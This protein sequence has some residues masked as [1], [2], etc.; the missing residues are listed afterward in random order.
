MTREETVRLLS[1]LRAAYPNFYKGMGK[2]ELEGTVSLW[3]ELFLEDD[4]TLVMT[5]AKAL[6]VSDAKGFPP[7]IG[8]IKDK[9]RLLSQPQEMGAEEA[10]RL[11]QKALSNGLYG[12]REEYEKLPER[13]QGLIG[14]PAVLRQYA[15]M[16]VGELETVVKSHFIKAYREKQEY[17]KQVD[18]LPE[19]VKRR[20]VA[21]AAIEGRITNG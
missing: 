12:S 10:W 8:Q 11:V 2:K 19:D 15:G 18:A 17:K 13:V 9:M 7:V 4:Y 21:A 6:I 14:S 5:A 16:D 1:V 20:L 3:A